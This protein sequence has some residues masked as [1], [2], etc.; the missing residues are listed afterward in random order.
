[1]ITIII[2][3]KRAF[4]LFLGC[5]TLFSATLVHAAEMETPVAV[6]A[7]SAQDVRELPS[8]SVD[9]ILPGD[10]R[11]APGAATTLTDQEIEQLRPYTMHDAF[12]FI[13]GVRT[14]DD[15]VLGR[16]SGIG[17]RGAPSRRSRKTLLLE[18]GVPINASTYLD[19]SAHYT[20]PMERL[21]AIDVL[22]GN[23][24]IL[25]GPL[26]NHGI[27][28]FRNKRPTSVPETTIELSG[29]EQSTFKR[30]LMHRRTEGSL[31]M[32]FSYT[33]ANADGVF[34]V[35]DTQYDDFFGSLD[36]QVNSQHSIGTSFLYFRERSHYDESNLLPAE[37]A[38]NPFTKAGRLV[39]FGG[40]TSATGWGQQHNT[41]A[42]DY[43]KA[44][45]THDYQIT[46][47][48]SMSNKIFATDLDRPRFTVD[49][50]EI[51]FD[52]AS[53]VLD[54]DAGGGTPFIAGVQGE[55]VSRDR[56]YRTYGGESRME[57]ANI[58]AFGLDHTFQWGARYERHFLAD[59]RYGG[60]AGEVLDEGNRGAR[61][62]E[63]DFQASAVS[64]FFQDAIQFG[65]WTV[66][67]GARVEYFTQ[68][69][70]R[71]PRSAD[72][73][74]NNF[75]L[76]DQNSVFL[77]GI[78][79]LY[80][81]FQ[82]TQV[83]ASVQRGYSPS[84][85]RTA[86][87]FPLVPETG[88]NSQ[89]GMRSSVF[90]GVSFEVAGFYNMLTDTIVQLPFSIAGQNLVINS[91]DSDVIGADV[92]LR[93]DSNAFYTATPYNVYGMLGYNYS[94]AEFTTGV[95]DGNR[96]PEVPLHA[97]SFTFG[98]EHTSGWDVGLTVSHFGSFFTDPANTK[99]FVVQDEDG[100]VLAAGD[101]L[102]IREPVVV[103]E[104]ESHTLLSARASYTLPGTS[105]TF[106]V[107]GRNLTDKLYITDL[108]NG[109]RPGAERTVVGGVQLE[110]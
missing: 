26:N 45:I 71:K 2:N 33:G 25:H 61:T 75:K 68:S 86:A 14:I 48:W 58:A 31:G 46:N 50:E 38:R 103:G 56:H 92:A 96:V 47:N 90:R 104:V 70:V 89:I 53:A 51:E 35:E 105:T 97:G 5:F 57:L 52:P 63:V 102:E 87:G 23:G 106:W 65:N 73:A 55:M 20:P 74:S 60:V 7:V 88:I 100:E 82:D 12:D 40:V 43:L 39:T 67:P 64:V 15:D 85:A 27:V 81:G 17:I 32:V 44:D 22:R 84:I 109:I 24:Q 72:P 37:F 41:I 19:S 62:R 54:F 6:S 1:M 28:N 42:I 9:A 98:I 3:S 4:S 83:F 107:Q 80:D 69:Q 13:P 16:R 10:I 34:D 79:F 49:P 108:Q 59:K 66:T 99:A 93:V 30:H 8:I 29:G 91:G 94:Q 95:L 36:W 21:E 76:T 77:P 11:F 18:D 110:F 101:A 78:S